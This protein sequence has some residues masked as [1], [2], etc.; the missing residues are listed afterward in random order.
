MTNGSNTSDNRPHGYLSQ[1]PIKTIAA[2]RS[3]AIR[4]K[5]QKRTTPRT[6]PENHTLK[7]HSACSHRKNTITS[8]QIL[9]DTSI[10]QETVEQ[11]PRKEFLLRY[12]STHN[13]QILVAPPPRASYHTNSS[14][15]S[16]TFPQRLATFSTSWPTTAPDPATMAR[17]GFHHE[18]HDSHTSSKD[19]A[20]CSECSISFS[21]WTRDEDSEPMS[22]HTTRSPKCP[23]VCEKQRLQEK[24]QQQEKHSVCKSQ[25]PIKSG[26]SSLKVAEKPPP[27][28]YQ[29]PKPS[30]FVWPEKPSSNPVSTTSYS[31]SASSAPLKSGASSLLPAETAAPPTY[32]S[33]SPPPPTYI[34][35]APKN[36]LTIQD[37]YMR[38]APLNQ[39]RSAS[40]SSA[41]KPRLA[42]YLT[43]KDLFLK[44]A[45]LRQTARRTVLV[46]Q[47]LG[48][49]ANRLRLPI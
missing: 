9:H 23:F 42:T 13:T 7:S 39:V 41:P 44:F 48:H 10:G 1:E 14:M 27:L 15:T 18:H 21:G 35:S 49:R 31:A 16:L 3:L 30:K 11:D 38:Y 34:A 25:A 6:S 26:A 12:S 46:R 32:R 28:T 24:Q 8:I 47:N 37:L 19:L 43:I 29:P 2:L 36:F 22:L 40:T 33:I 4:Q 17:A 45:S 5:R 20:A